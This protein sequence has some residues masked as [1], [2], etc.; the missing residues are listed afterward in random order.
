MVRQGSD[1]PDISERLNGSHAQS[2][3]DA[4]ADLFLGGENGHAPAVAASQPP[5]SPSS[6]PETATP[7]ITV[8]TRADASRADA[9]DSNLGMPHGP[10]C[11]RVGPI[12]GAATAKPACRRIDVLVLG[13]LPGMGGTWAA[14]HAHAAAQQLKSSV[15]LLR[16]SGGELVVDLIWPDDARPASFPACTDAA[17]ALRL[18]AQHAGAWLLRVQTGDEAALRDWFAIPAAAAASDS[19]V[20]RVRLLTGADDAAIIAAYG[21]LKAWHAAAPHGFARLARVTIVE[22][23]AAR[24]AAAES[25]LRKAAASFL[26]TELAPTERLGAMRPVRM[27][28]LYCGPFESGARGALTLIRRISADVPQ[29]THASMPGDVA[30]EHAPA[31]QHSTHPFADTRQ[32]SSNTPNSGAND[33]PASNSAAASS[34]TTTGRVLAEATASRPKPAA[35]RHVAPS[36]VHAL[37]S[38]TA[39][40][41]IAMIARSAV[42]DTLRAA[43]TTCPWAPAIVLAVDAYGECHAIAFAHDEARV[44]V[45]AVD[46]LTASRWCT[47]HASLL[48]MAG[49]TPLASDTTLHL[50]TTAPAAARRLA[51]TGLRVHAAVRVGESWGA[52]SLS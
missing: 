36:A 41:I 18:A 3:Y 49:V 21:R 32:D 9:T 19:A 50:I 28:T 31:D 12:G 45:A 47:E 1:R 30:A 8:T 29:T 43:P 33:A 2:D 42:V 35:A 27:T 7:V 22:P 38:P 44:C 11:S 46:L 48:A 17:A 6:N 52:V 13:H 39:D 16:L 15:C 40:Q 37:H 24:A 34:T 10:C 25:R 5:H 20:D 23:D 26:D 51:D 4:L 14:Q